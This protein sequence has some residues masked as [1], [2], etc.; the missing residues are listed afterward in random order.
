MVRS[1]FFG[2]EGLEAFACSEVAAIVTAGRLA[3]AAMPALPIRN[4]RRDREGSTGGAMAGLSSGAGLVVE[5]A[6]FP[7]KKKGKGRLR[8]PGSC[9]PAASLPIP[10]SQEA[11]YGAHSAAL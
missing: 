3:A 6:E 10:H 4:R 2:L 8:H 9:G 7:R 5:I 1:P 11:Q